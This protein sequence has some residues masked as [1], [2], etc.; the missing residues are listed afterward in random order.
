MHPLPTG[1]CCVQYADPLIVTEPVPGVPTALPTTTITVWLATVIT[2]LK[3]L[4]VVPGAAL[5]VKEPEPV[6]LAPAVIVSQGAFGAADHTHPAPA[7]TETVAVPPPGGR[8]TND[9][10]GL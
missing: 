8:V 9:G 1:V 5:S 7:V 3:L 4:L 2:L 10:S 6:P